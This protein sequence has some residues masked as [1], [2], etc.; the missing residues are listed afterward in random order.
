MV[1]ARAAIDYQEKSSKCTGTAP[2]EL[3]EYSMILGRNRKA[4]ERILEFV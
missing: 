4:G 1:L 2:R 3:M